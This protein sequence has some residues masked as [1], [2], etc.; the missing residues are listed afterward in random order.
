[1]HLQNSQ[2][3]NCEDLRFAVIHF[4]WW[5]IIVPDRIL[6][7]QC[8]HRNALCR[9][10]GSI[11]SGACDQ[12]GANQRQIPSP[13]RRCWHVWRGCSTAGRRL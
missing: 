5:Q 10:F 12:I 4:S 6:F 3:A 11:N 2:A 7:P 9:Y 8:P 13:L 1:M